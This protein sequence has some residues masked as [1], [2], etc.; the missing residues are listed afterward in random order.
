MNSETFIKSVEKGEYP[1]NKELLDSLY[2]EQEDLLKKMANHRDKGDIGTYKNLVK[3]LA[4]VTAL[5]DNMWR[6]CPIRYGVDKYETMYSKYSIDNTN[7]ISIWEQN[8]KGDIKN[9][10]KF[11]LYD[12]KLFNL[13]I[14]LINQI[15]IANFED[16]NGMFLKNNKSFVDLRKYVLKYIIKE[17]DINLLQLRDMTNISE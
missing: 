8:S 11:K 6:S 9:E 7:M 13:I 10:K 17:K 4:D 5:I 12:D 15:D 2:L 16:S 1:I 3:S 14:T